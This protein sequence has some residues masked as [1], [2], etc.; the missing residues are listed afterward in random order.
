MKFKSNLMTTEEIMRALKRIA[1][2]IAEKNNGV[3]NVVVLGIKKGGVPLAHQLAS[4]LKTME[5]ID[6]PVGELDIS[7]HRD[8]LKTR[9]TKEEE[10]PVGSNIPCDIE[11]KDVVLVDDV[12]YT[13]RTARAAFDALSDFGRASTI[14]LAVLIDRGHRE[15]PIRADYVG[16]NIPTSHTEIISVD[17]D[18]QGGNPMV[19]IYDL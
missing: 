18:D 6:L 11:G 14:Q 17:F 5:E 1:H 15:L 16:K 8:D 2:Q 13:G 3:E 12:L 9:K 10:G 4:Y 19:N 7:A